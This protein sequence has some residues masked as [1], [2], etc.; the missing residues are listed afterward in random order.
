[1][2]APPG[3]ERPRAASNLPAAQEA[4]LTSRSALAVPGYTGHIPGKG[5][6]VQNMG[7]RFAAANI[8]GMLSA[9]GNGGGRPDKLLEEP[10]SL[11]G[12]SG[13]IPG[14][15]GYL[16]G[17]VEDHYASTWTVANTRAEAK[18]HS[19]NEHEIRPGDGVSK[20]A[21]PPRSPAVCS[22]RVDGSQARPGTG[23]AQKAV[24]GYAGHIPGKKAEDVAGNRFAATNA[25]A[26]VEFGDRSAHSKTVWH[27][28][29]APGVV[30]R[31]NP[32]ASAGKAVPGYAGHVHGK[33]P[34]AGLMGVRFK[35]ANEIADDAR[36][37][38]NTSKPK[39]RAYEQLAKPKK[40]SENGQ[41]ARSS[42]VGS[43]ARHS[44]R[45]GATSSKASVISTALSSAT[46]AGRSSV[47]RPSKASAD[48]PKLRASEDKPKPARA[49]GYSGFTPQNHT[50]VN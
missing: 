2:S 4:Q 16:P 19:G 15:S 36:V 20:F 18:T 35:V 40:N 10:K 45:S 50:W 33:R 9:R 17:K 44:A 47:S 26:S 27:R 12:P 41:S 7:K 34:E 24:P 42:Q 48:K 39:G 38:S 30:Q 28:P 21:P 6:V 31:L 3:P 5:P 49:E 29:E 11:R 22:P 43:A 46:S 13:N 32:G 37:Q 14:Y 23:L 8:D 1:M 25:I